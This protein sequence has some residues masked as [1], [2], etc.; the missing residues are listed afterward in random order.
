MINSLFNL[1]E[2]LIEQYIVVESPAFESHEPA[3]PTAN[4]AASTSTSACLA[5]GA[6]CPIVI[7]VL[8]LHFVTG[9][10]IVELIELAAE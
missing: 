9:P 4:A 1:F 7:A 6:N 10:A 5:A 3:L 8:V 2:V